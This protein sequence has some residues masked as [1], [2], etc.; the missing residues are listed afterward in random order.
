[1]TDVLTQ[2]LLERAL[3]AATCA[4]GHPRGQSIWES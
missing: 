4:I 3:A 2:N 1:M